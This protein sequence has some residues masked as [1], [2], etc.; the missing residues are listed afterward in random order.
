MVN[1]LQHARDASPS[2]AS[3]HTRS[4]WFGI[5]VAVLLFVVLLVFILQNTYSVE[6]RF[7]WL[8]GS[9]PLGL[10]AVTVGAALTYTVVG[11]ARIARLRR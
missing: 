9:L 3:S 2:T 4:A 11:A 7:L 10:F 6:V 5:G 8:R 1:N